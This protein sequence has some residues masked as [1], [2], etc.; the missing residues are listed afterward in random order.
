[1]LACLAALLV[2]QAPTPLPAADATRLRTE[3]VEALAE[4]SE[5]A[6]KA[7]GKLLAW[8]RT[9]ESK[10]THASLMA[11]LRQ[12]PRLPAGDPQPRGRGKDKEVHTR[13]GPTTHGFRFESGGARIS[14]L[15]DVPPDY[16]PAR[17]APL[18]VDPGHG[19]GAKLDAKGKIG[20]VPYFRSGADEGGLAAALVARTEILEQIGADGLRGASEE[21]I[22]AAAFDDFF[23]DLASRFAFDPDRVYVAGIS[24]SGFWSWY[25]GR[26][27]PDRYAGLAPIAAVTWQVDAY[28]D[29]FARLPIVVVH[30]SEDKVCPVAQ[31]RAT[32]AKL[33]ERGSPCTYIEVE[34]AGHDGG[35]FGRL[36]QAL[37]QLSKHTRDPWPKH[38]QR[39]LLSTRNPWCAWVRVVR[40]EREGD[41]R[42]GSPPVARVEARVEGQLITLRTQGVRELELWPAGELLDLAQPVEVRWNDA[43]VHSGPLQPR[44]SEALE[45]ALAR[46]DWKASGELRLALKAPR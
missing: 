7:R 26:A 16:D 14:Y 11:A 9:L 30:G 3:M 43:L 22:V 1:M 33:G 4:P 44:F 38:V 17:P 41:G 40:L 21:E 39:S 13:V 46:A 36:G 29:C 32:T 35:V 5:P 19:S 10:H 27:R 12:G 20:F 6:G 24:Q 23:R 31:P 37:E 25:L 34:G 15:V 8:A 28:L 42:A 18:L 45:N 2:A